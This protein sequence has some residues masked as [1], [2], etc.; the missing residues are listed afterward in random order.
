MS[1]DISPYL[2]LMVKK[3]ASDLFFSTGSKVIIKIEGQCMPVGE[4]VLAPGVVKQIA[5]QMMS[6]RQLAEFERELEMNLGLSVSGVGRFRVNVFQQRG[7]VSMVIRYVKNDIPT[8]EDLGLPPILKNFSM[9]KRGLVLMVGAT[10]SGKSTS[11]AAMI[12]YRNA[13][14][15][16]H[17]LTIEDPIE[18]L[19]RHKRSVVNQREIGFDT[20]NYHNALINALREAPDVIL[21]GEIRDRETMESAIKYSETGHLCLS[22]LHANNANQTLDRIINFFPDSAHRQLLLD[23]SLNLRGIVSQRLLPGKDEKKR[24]VAVEVMLNTPYIA[25]LIQEGKIPEIKNIMGKGTDQGMQTFDQALYDLYAA[26]RITLEDALE[27]ADSKNDLALRIRMSG[28]PDAGYG[29]L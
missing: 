15:A 28:G 10:G 18:F 21:I 27:N 12:D 4:M 20:H 9:V 17:I 6:D 25:Q 11:L 26:G 14:S 1:T 24:V 7:E 13:N 19:H 3:Q 8:I 16:G 22:T 23:L 29:S 2:Q 5:Y